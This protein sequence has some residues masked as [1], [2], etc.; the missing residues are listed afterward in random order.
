MPPAEILEIALRS[1]AVAGGATLLSLV[2]GVLAAYALGMF[3]AGHAADRADLRIFLAVG[4]LG[5][6][7]LTS[8]VGMAYFWDIHSMG[9]FLVVQVAAGLFQSTGWP[10]VVAVMANWF[11][12]N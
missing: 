9:Y 8:M 2:L 10:A 12:K 4:M 6:G 1:L 11:G 5:S 7:L 3:F